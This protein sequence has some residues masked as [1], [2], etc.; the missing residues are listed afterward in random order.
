MGPCKVVGVPVIAQVVLLMESPAGN[1]GELVQEVIEPPDD[2]GVTGIMVEFC[3]KL[4]FGL[5]TTRYEGGEVVVATP[6]R[7]DVVVLP[8]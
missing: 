7:R 4:T 2:V 5:K 1:A 8:Y 6:N 3:F